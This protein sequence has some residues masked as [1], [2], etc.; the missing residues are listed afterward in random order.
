MA[1]R[2]EP[3]PELGDDINQNDNN[4]ELIEKLNENI[5]EKDDEEEENQEEEEEKQDEEKQPI[6]KLLHED[7]IEDIDDDNT[8]TI[9][10]LKEESVFS[11]DNN[12]EQ[13]YDLNYDDQKELLLNDNV[14]ITEGG[15]LSYF[16]DDPHN[17]LN[18]RIIKTEERKSR[19]L[20]HTVYI[21]QSSVFNIS[22]SGTST[23]SRRYNDFKWLHHVLSV[24]YLGILYTKYC[25]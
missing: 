1:E 24:E 3:V 10:K 17:K 23:V 9:Q 6:S 18:I 15:I 13:K 16:G 22:N 4:D 21:V 8:E 14:I 19:I 2:E 5:V 25:M 11:A 7:D 12:N 20:K